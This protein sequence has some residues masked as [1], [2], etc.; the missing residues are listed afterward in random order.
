[1]KFGFELKSGVER[2]LSGIHVECLE[3]AEPV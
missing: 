3:M 1:M 2:P